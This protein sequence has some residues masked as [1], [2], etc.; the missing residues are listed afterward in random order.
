MGCNANESYNNC[1]LTR[2]LS[3][4]PQTG[5]C[6]TSAQVYLTCT[7][8]ADLVLLPHFEVNGRGVRT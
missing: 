7:T 5:L 3:G 4:T 2:K 6:W 8:S 1:F